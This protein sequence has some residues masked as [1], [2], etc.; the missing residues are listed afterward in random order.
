MSTKRMRRRGVRGAGATNFRAL[1]PHFLA[2]RE[3]KSSNFPFL[4]FNKLP[5]LIKVRSR[6]LFRFLPSSFEH[7]CFVVRIVSFSSIC[8]GCFRVFVF[9]VVLK[10]DPVEDVIPP[11]LHVHLVSFVSYHP[12]M[13]TAVL[14]CSV[15]RIISELQ[16]SLDCRGRVSRLFRRTTVILLLHVP[17]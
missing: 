10:R 11:R 16:H 5:L 2:D 13:I 9:T 17:I 7:C 14:F 3:L 6:G 1:G 8:G 12:R 15:L 4:Q